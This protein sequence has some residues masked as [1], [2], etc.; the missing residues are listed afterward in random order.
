MRASMAGVTI[1]SGPRLSPTI[2]ELQFPR[3]L[4]WNPILRKG[5]YSRQLGDWDEWLPGTI[6]TYLLL[7]VVPQEFQQPH[8]VFVPDEDREPA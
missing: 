2:T 7:L 4:C 6:V 3:T 5:F 8:H 1:S